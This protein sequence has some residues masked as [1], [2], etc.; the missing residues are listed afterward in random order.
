MNNKFQI[1]SG[2]TG[3]SNEQYLEINWIQNTHNNNNSNNNNN[4]NNHC[5]L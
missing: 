4:N 3:N 1:H 5:H 2:T